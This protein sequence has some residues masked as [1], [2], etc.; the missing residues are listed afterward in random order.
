MINLPYDNLVAVAY[1]A[2]YCG[3]LM[4]ILLALSPEVAQYTP[5]KELSF[6]GGTAH[7]YTENWFNKL[8]DYNDSLTV[9]EENWPNYLTNKSIDALSSNKLVIFRC[10][11][12]SAYKLGEFIKNLRVVYMT[13]ENPYVCERWI[14]EKQLKKH[15]NFFIKKSV[16]QI[17]KQPFVKEVTNQISRNILIRN[18][19]HTVVSFDQSKSRLK[20]NIFQMQIEKLLN[21]D[22]NVYLEVCE[23]LKITAINIETFI[24][25]IKKYNDKQWK[26]F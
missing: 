2:G 1:K 26:R 23:F 13:H 22:Y 21:Y 25:I 18:F 9:S 19:N 8:H 17:S 11:P 3:S 10:H 20:E 6:A 7:E 24:S 4:Y 12:N 15:L 14:Y 16:E 5:I